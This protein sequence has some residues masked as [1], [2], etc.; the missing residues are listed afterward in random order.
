MPD[1]LAEA[2]KLLQNEVPKTDSA[3]WQI[4]E[5]VLSKFSVPTLGEDLARECLIQII[6]YVEFPND[7]LAQRLVGRAEG[8]A[9]ELW[10]DLSDEPHMSEL[11]WKDY[12]GFQ[13]Y[14]GRTE[15]S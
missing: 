5:A 7:E 1:A 13:K 14:G 15:S 10:D 9:T 6:C 3:R 4:A 8:L 11:E 12:K 2:Y